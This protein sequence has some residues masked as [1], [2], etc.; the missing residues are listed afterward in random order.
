MTT[1]KWDIF[2]DAKSA[3]EAKGHATKR[4]LDDRRFS[5]R[6]VA[7]V[8]SR[9]IAQNSED[10]EA[11]MA[12]VRPNASVVM[13]TPNL[14]DIFKFRI[15][16]IPEA[17]LK[18]SADE[19]IPDVSSIPRSF[20][21]TKS[22]RMVSL[23]MVAWSKKG[24]KG[25]IPKIDDLVIVECFYSDFKMSVSLENCEFVEIL[26]SDTTPN[27]LQKRR[28][29]VESKLMAL[30]TGDWTGIPEQ[31]AGHTHNN[32]PSMPG[33][34]GETPPA[35]KCA[36]G[37]FCDK[38]YRALFD[39]GPRS[40]NPTSIVIHATA[41]GMG[42]SKALQG[43]RRCAKKPYGPTTHVK[44]TRNQIAAGGCEK[45]GD[46]YY[47]PCNGSEICTAANDPL[48]RRQTKTSPHY[49]VDQGGNVVE[50]CSPDRIGHHAPGWNSVSLGIEHAGHPQDH[51][52]MWTPELLKA[53]AKLSAGLCWRYGIHPRK[54]ETNDKTQNGFVGHEVIS[55]DRS[56]PG[57]HFPWDDYL[58]MVKKFMN[59][60]NHNTESPK[61]I[62][63][64][65][66]AEGA[67]G[68]PR[69]ASPSSEAAYLLTSDGDTEI[70][71]KC[72]SGTAFHEAGSDEEQSWPAGCYDADGVY[73]DPVSG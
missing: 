27:D 70:D 19:G 14:K 29:E 21:A 8:Y 59:E 12:A 35:E 50:A 18:Y 31:H 6:Q 69:D 33:G 2:T 66:S 30:Y 44:C 73:Y 22:A 45:R 60:K 26:R 57:E 38:R 20:N 1:T 43:A 28:G 25:K 63:A 67:D 58:K 51:P 5:K 68:R 54:I 64:G 61:D 52:N 53:S 9:A 56:D 47:V 55:D 71:Q 49:Y 10:A 41:G 3:D 15:K 34:T 23:M 13:Q 48:F 46:T 16:L 42:D 65:V 36:T 4:A 17:E 7:R 62:A 24:Y 72:P 11:L 37:E 32:S 40:R 39:S